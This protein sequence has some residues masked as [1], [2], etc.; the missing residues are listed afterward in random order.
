MSPRHHLAA[1]VVACLLG[2][3]CAA[4]APEDPPA[5]ADGPDQGSETGPAGEAGAGAGEEETSMS[6]ADRREMRRR[7][8]ERNRKKLERAPAGR[9]DE[10][11]VTGE[12]PGEIL[13]EIVADLA[14]ALGA[15]PGE[16]EVLHDEAV[17]WSD[18]SLGCP[19][20]DKVYMQM[21][22]PGYRV[23]LGHGGQQ[24]D[25]RASERGTFRLCERPDLAALGAGRE[26][27]VE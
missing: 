19:E 4:L 10:L 16:I 18:G 1:A 8:A 13:E 2:A 23:I 6:D 5:G 7:L 12:V 21:L 14:Q 27:P 22:V 9:R 26:P 3:A 17:T 15:A 11:A 25:Y 20:P 24:Y